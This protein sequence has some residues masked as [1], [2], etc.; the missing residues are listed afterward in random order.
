MKRLKIPLKRGNSEVDIIF[1]RIRKDKSIRC[2]RIVVLGLLECP[3]L[4]QN[5]HEIFQDSVN[6]FVSLTANQ[7]IIIYKKYR[8]RN[9][10]SKFLIKMQDSKHIHVQYNFS[11]KTSPISTC[12]YYGQ[13]I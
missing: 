5:I 12:L 3:D 11:P 10:N 7:K 2:F 8:E 9:E 1:I 13:F 4:K 6:G